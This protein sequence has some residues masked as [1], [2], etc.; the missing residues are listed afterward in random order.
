MPPL[1]LPERTFIVSDQRS[2]MEDVLDVYTRSYD[3]A[4]PLVCLDET[5][6]QRVAETRAPEL[7]QPGQPTRHDYEYK[8]N[9]TA[10]LFM[11]FAPLSERLPRC[12]GQIAARQA[13]LTINVRLRA[14]VMSRSP[15]GARPS[16]TRKS[17]VI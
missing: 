2:L 5:S 11:L 17:C 13:P 14:G 6:K 8:R 16:T 4:R 10:N 12:L 3:S 1:S 15:S 7:M 9:G